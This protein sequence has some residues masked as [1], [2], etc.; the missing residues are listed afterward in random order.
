MNTTEIIQVNPVEYG[1]A[2]NKATELIGNLPQIQGERK[3]LEQVYE[4]IVLLDIEDKETSKKAKELRLKIKDN[5]TKGIEVW[6]KTTKE[7][8]LKGGQFV[9]AIKRK[10]IAV[11][12]RMEEMLESIEKYAENL[13]KERKSKLNAERIELLEPFDA[14]VPLGLN[15]GEISDDEFAKI[16]NG[17]K[18]QFEQQKKEEEEAEA[19]KQR[20]AEILKLHNQRKEKVLPIWQFVPEGFKISNMGLATEMEFIS[21]LNEANKSKK[22]FDAEQVKIKAENERLAK[23]K[24]D[25]E[26]KTKK[27]K[28]ESETKALKAKQ[29]ADAILKAERDAKAKLEAEL[30]AKRNAEIKAEN[31]RKI[32]EENAKKEAQKLAK[33]PIKEQLNKW[34][35][36]FSIELPNSELLN[37]EKALLIKSKFDAF[38]K[39][40]KSEIESL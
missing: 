13:E 36:N 25:L 32:A 15:F 40:A 7:F 34:V 23:E 1:I 6:H 18:L 21:V 2:E 9:D 33:A 4:K 37:N 3:L 22:K 11:N 27:D 17:A 26:A 29:E 12:E 5:R 30:Q 35:D 8:F 19:E 28:E 20:Q 24:A 31:D 16:F 10:E 14:F 39:W 38:K